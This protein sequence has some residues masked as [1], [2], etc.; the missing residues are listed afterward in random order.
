MYIYTAT[1]VDVHDGDTITVDIDMGFGLIF[2]KQKLRL[3]GINAP[4]L[5]DSSG[6]GIKARDILIGLV[7]NKPIIINTIKD[8][9]EKYGRY[10]ANISSE[11]VDPKIDITLFP[12][13]NSWL[14]SNGYAKPYLI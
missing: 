9:K 5:G 1:V 12:T 7:L 3:Y 10:L 6:E 14:V 11:G 13:I 8:E 2:R 4:E